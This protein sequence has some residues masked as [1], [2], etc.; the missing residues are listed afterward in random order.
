MKALSA[1]PPKIG[2]QSVPNFPEE[3]EIYMWWPQHINIHFDI[4][5]GSLENTGPITIHSATI[6]ETRCPHLHRVSQ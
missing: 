5:I 3:V 4:A 1:N 6:P 2:D